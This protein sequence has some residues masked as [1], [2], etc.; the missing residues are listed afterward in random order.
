MTT[1]YSGET[2]HESR[3]SHGDRPDLFAQLYRNDLYDNNNELL[4]R[5][6]DKKRQLDELRPLPEE[7]AR[8]LG[9]TYDI[10]LANT[11]NALE[12]NT[13]TRNETLLAIQHGL[14]AKQKPNQDFLES[15]N[16]SHAWQLVEALA[17]KKD[18]P[19][20]NNDILS[21]HGIILSGIRDDQ[22]GKFREMQVTIDG[23]LVVLPP[24]HQVPEYMAEFEA[25]LNN[26]AQQL[27][28]LE[29]AQE[30]HYRLTRI[31]PF[32]DGNGRTARLLMNMLL[33]RDGYTPAII[34]LEDRSRYLDYLETTDRTGTIGQLDRFVGERVEESLD[35]YLEVARGN[36]S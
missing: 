25:W 10:L 20:T 26:D 5:I 23:Q 16:H 14:R 11:S 13:Y 8:S 35:R 32:V 18:V 3:E 7:T 9:R 17:L 27:H 33:V 12:G 21:M 15:V 22:A 24:P 2:H 30:A 28:P 31:H 36:I 19:I 34:A 6:D 29:R 4:G 1:Y